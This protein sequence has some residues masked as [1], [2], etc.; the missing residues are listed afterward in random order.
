MVLYHDSIL[1]L[2]ANWSNPFVVPP[3]YHNW[4]PWVGLH[5]SASYM[6]LNTEYTKVM[7]AHPATG[8]E[9]NITEDRLTDELLTFKVGLA[10][11]FKSLLY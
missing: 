7:P 10:Q 5:T 2:K 4:A 11:S 3:S 8:G 6:V 1:S 9:F